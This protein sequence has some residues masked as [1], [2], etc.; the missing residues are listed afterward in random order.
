[1]SSTLTNRCSQKVLGPIIAACSNLIYLF[2]CKF[3]Q[4]I[5]VT[6]CSLF[7]CPQYNLYNYIKS[8]W[9]SI[10]PCWLYIYSCSN[11]PSGISIATCIS[12]V[13]SNADMHLIPISLRIIRGHKSKQGS[14]ASSWR[15][16]SKA[17]SDCAQRSRAS[18][19]ALV[20]HLLIN[21]QLFDPH[22]FARR[23]SIGEGQRVLQKFH[24]KMNIMRA[25][26][27]SAPYYWCSE[28]QSKTAEVL[29]SNHL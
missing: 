10:Q 13:L 5:P 22:R 11:P 16:E 29:R 1:M 2:V 28:K 20:L 6:G 18:C 17:D 15:R 7:P 25:W 4:N 26:E 3:V 21:R 23:G 27:C 14:L 19:D 24:K 12:A 9:L 8:P